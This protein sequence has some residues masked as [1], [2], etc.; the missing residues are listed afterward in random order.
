[1]SAEIDE[2]PSLRFQDIRTDTRTDGRKDGQR[3]NSIYPPPPHTH[4]QTKFA[5]GGGYKNVRED[6]QEMAQF[7]NIALPRPGT[8]KFRT[9]SAYPCRV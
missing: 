3:E 9:Q 7:R 4:T 8:A 5:G 6:A 2:Y 1:M